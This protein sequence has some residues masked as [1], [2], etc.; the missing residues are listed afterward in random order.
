M[1]GLATLAYTR[2]HE[3]TSKWQSVCGSE[4]VISAA[5]FNGS[6]EEDGDLGTHLHFPVVLFMT[7]IYLFSVVC[8]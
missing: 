5:W 7:E 1:H 3:D 6:G 2:E 8:S 4:G